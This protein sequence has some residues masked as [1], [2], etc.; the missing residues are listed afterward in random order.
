MT[1]A[2]GQKYRPPLMSRWSFLSPCKYSKPINSSR[3]MIVM[4]SSGISP[5]FMRSPQLPP[6]Q[7]SMII[8]KSEPLRN[9]PWY[10]VT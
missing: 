5:G 1:Q 8:H 6:E 7:N 2:I 10:L 9:D 3:M 4:Y